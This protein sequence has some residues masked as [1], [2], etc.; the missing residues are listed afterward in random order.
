MSLR[1]TTSMM[2][3][4]YGSNLRDLQNTL[5]KKMTQ[6]Y[7]YRSFD[8]PSDDPLLASQAFQVEWEMTETAITKTM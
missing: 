3:G 5:S 7:T 1:I 6:A 4:N 2:S 8:L